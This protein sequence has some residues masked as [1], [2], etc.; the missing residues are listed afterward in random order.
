MTIGFLILGFLF[1]HGFFAHLPGAVRTGLMILCAASFLFFAGVEGMIIKGAIQAPA[2]GLNYVIVLGAHVRSTGP[3]R[4]LALR[5]D[6]AYTYALENPDAVLIVSG[7]QGSNEPWHGSVFHESISDEKRASRRPD[8]HGRPVHQHPG[9]SDLLR[10]ADT[11]Q[12]FRR[13]R[14]QRLSYLSCPCT[15]QR[16]WD[17]KTQQA[18]RQKVILS[19]SR[20]TCCGNSLQL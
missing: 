12:C 4:A 9:K 11:G 18:F 6:R 2:A 1:H 14:K 7:G 3:S 16:Y 20:Q 5:L 13:Y 10:A 15:L 17:T 8:P 19:P